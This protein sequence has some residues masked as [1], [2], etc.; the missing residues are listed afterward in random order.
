MTAD[1]HF[2]PAGNDDLQVELRGQV[3][4]LTI[5]RERRRNAIS[6]GVFQGISD[7]ILYTRR[8]ASLRAIVLTGEGDKAFC[9]GADLQAGDPF[10]VDYANPFGPAADL[11]RLAR[12][13]T[14]PMVARVNGACFA[15][16]MGLMAMCDLVVA[17]SHATFALP[18]IKVGIF[19][20]QVLALLQHLLPRRVLVHMCLTGAALSAEEALAL[21]LVNS[22][23]ADLDREISQLL[24]RLAAGS[25]VAI[26]RG[27]YML[28]KIE[29]MPFEEAVSFAE[30]QITLFSQSADAKEGLAAFN[31]KRAP[32]WPGR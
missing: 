25:P 31:Q 12:Q 24:D 13:S 16:G 9:A 3:L 30:G 14:V 21:H 6:P 7:G 8:D 10:L 19:P 11:F 27:V 20:A 1:T 5:T 26:R 22:V 4:W 15:G 29:S 23:A 18:E 17:A 2:L 32:A 28:K